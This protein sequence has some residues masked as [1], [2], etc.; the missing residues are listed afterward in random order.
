MQSVTSTVEKPRR[1]L[2]HSDGA[3][4]CPMCTHTVRAT[5]ILNNRV[6]RVAPG[7]RCPRCSASLDAGYVIEVNRAA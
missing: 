4:Y 3:V 1:A 6:T 5:V 2:Q 7:Q